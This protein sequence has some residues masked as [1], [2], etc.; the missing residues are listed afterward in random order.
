M[1]SDLTREQ[2]IARASNKLEC[3]LW[4][5]NK[6]IEKYEL[7]LEGIMMTKL[8]PEQIQESLEAERREYDTINHIFNLIESSY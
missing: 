3:M 2:L 8:D 6:N 1:I 5:S 4:A 7:M